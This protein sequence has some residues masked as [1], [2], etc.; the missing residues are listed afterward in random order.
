MDLAAD[1][2][3]DDTGDQYA[4]GQR[5]LTGVVADDGELHDAS[6]RKNK[7]DDI[8]GNLCI[9]HE[10][11]IPFERWVLVFGRDRCPGFGCY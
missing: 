5:L 7:P 1:K 11:S 6:D 2:C 8:E 4:E 10:I 9:L 3:A